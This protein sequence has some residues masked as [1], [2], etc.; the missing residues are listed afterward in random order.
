MTASAAP[1]P[2]NA[3]APQPIAVIRSYSALREAI[4]AWCAA[5][6][7]TRAEL[8]TEAG[9]GDG[10]SGKLLSAREIKK[11]GNVTLGRVLAATGTVLILAQDHEAPAQAAARSHASSHASSPPPKHWRTN[12]G[13]AWGRRMA[14]RRALKLSAAERSASARKA[15]QARWHRPRSTP[16]DK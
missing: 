3:T 13:R 5:T 12:K 6:G 2:A 16:A 9:L 15:A 14:A 8:D 7:M 10:H 11:L 4:T 1:Q